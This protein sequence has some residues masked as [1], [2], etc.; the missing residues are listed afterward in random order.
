MAYGGSLES[1]PPGKVSPP[2]H[3][4]T[5]LIV[6]VTPNSHFA[7][8]LTDKVTPSQFPGGVNEKV[9]FRINLP[10]PEDQQWY[11]GVI[12]ESPPQKK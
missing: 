10:S 1:H 12:G 9:T 11:M 3:F 8:H 4:A 5:Q 7:I 6:K 2:S